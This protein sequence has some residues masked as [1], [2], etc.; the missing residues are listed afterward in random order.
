M[1]F[2]LLKQ[3]HHLDI[4]G[5]GMPPTY[6]VNDGKRILILPL[7][8]RKQ[9]RWLLKRKLWKFS[10][11]IYIDLFLLDFLSLNLSV[12]DLRC[13]LGPQPSSAFYLWWPEYYLWWSTD[14]QVNWYSES[15]QTHW[16]KNPQPHFSFPTRFPWFVYTLMITVIWL[17]NYFPLITV[18]VAMIMKKTGKWTQCT[19]FCLQSEL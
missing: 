12:C 5:T 1:W 18:H 3:N 6:L 14:F 19:P 9:V 15:T 10:V 7:H 17:S 11:D 4:Q 16:R 8:R 2:L 13:F